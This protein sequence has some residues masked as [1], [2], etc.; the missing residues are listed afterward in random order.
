LDLTNV[1]SRMTSQSLRDVVLAKGERRLSAPFIWSQASCLATGLV[2]L[3][4]QQG[5][6]VV[7]WMHSV[8]EVVVSYF[9]VQLSGGCF[10]PVPAS[11]QLDEFEE[12]VLRSKGA[13]TLI[14][15]DL[16]DRYCMVEK[17][18]ESV[19]QLIVDTGDATA[20]TTLPANARALTPMLLTG[21]D[22]TLPDIE[23]D[24]RSMC[25]IGENGKDLVEVYRKEGNWIE[26]IKSAEKSYKS[27]EKVVNAVELLDPD[28]LLLGTVWPLL[29][30][31][32]VYIPEKDAEKIDV[33]AEEQKFDTAILDGDSL[34]RLQ[35]VLPGKGVKKVYWKGPEFDRGAAM[36]EKI[37]GAKTFPLSESVDA[38]EFLP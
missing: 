27:G 15:L 30:G 19:R 31:A 10:V 26:A 4:L 12:I 1:F 29:A 3:G 37:V 20:E 11:A 33:A 6:G 36:V 16:Y 34:A 18:L 38:A 23:P 22:V 9:A 21:R 8:P 24:T 14:S 5:D 13:T 25:Y 7:A 2:G 28:A 32:S 17:K 35:D